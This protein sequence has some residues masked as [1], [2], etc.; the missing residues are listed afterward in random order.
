MGEKKVEATKIFL[1]W[2]RMQLFHVQW[3]MNMEKE[4]ELRQYTVILLR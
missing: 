1:R 2:E 4:A 3:T